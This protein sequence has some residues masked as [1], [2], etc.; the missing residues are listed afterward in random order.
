[1][2]HNRYQRLRGFDEA[3]LT[4]EV[5]IACVSVGAVAILGATLG[6]REPIAFTRVVQT[7]SS[8]AATGRSRDA[9]EAASVW[10]R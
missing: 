5:P 2:S 1:M 4:G 8:E 9:T 7:P 6:L 3:L 10:T